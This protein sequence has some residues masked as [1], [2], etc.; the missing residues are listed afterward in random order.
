MILYLYIHN[1]NKT[2]HC[3][4]LYPHIA[5]FK[6]SLFTAVG[7]FQRHPLSASSNLNY[8]IKTQIIFQIS[9]ELTKGFLYLPARTTTANTFINSTFNSENVCL[10]PAE[11]FHPF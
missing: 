11:A 7:T 6:V 5:P 1:S 3:P 10:T 4:V 9:L 8:I 2:H